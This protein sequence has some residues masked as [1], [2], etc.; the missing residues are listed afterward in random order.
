MI[1]YWFFIAL[2]YLSGSLLFGYLLP[3]WLWHMD[4]TGQSQ[5]GNP[6]TANAFLCAGMPVGIAVLVLELGK[7]FLPVHWAG[8]ILDITNPLFGLVIAAPVVGH[9]FPFWR[10]RGGGKAIAASF[11]ALLGLLPE[12]RPLLLLAFFYLL[13]S[14]LIVIQPHFYRSVVTF[15]LFSAGCVWLVKNPAFVFGCVVLSAV[16]IYKHFA[17]YQGERLQIQSLRESLRER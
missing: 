3:K 13:F 14:L 17:R 6:G 2:G 7:A 16:V 8:R 10:L 4:I 11:G 9:A 5:D 15:A 12:W 1:Q